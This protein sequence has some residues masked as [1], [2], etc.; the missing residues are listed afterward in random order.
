MASSIILTS[1]ELG[2][3]AALVKQDAKVVRATLLSIGR[4]T[5]RLEAYATTL[6]SI[7]VKLGVS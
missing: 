3:L 4:W 5:P 2:L 7:S 6:T 1:Q